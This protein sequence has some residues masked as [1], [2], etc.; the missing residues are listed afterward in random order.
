MAAKVKVRIKHRSMGQ[1]AGEVVEVEKDH[2]EH[3]IANGN[4]VRVQ[5]EKKSGD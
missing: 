5:D 3:L 1:P 2:A 4:A